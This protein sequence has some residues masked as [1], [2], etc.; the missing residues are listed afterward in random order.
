MQANSGNII[1]IGMPGSGTSSAPSKVQ[2]GLWE[3]RLVTGM[4]SW[5]QVIRISKEVGIA[6]M[7]RRSVRIRSAMR[8]NAR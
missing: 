6:K 1:L 5:A 2:S 7:E 4:P 3:N 8:I